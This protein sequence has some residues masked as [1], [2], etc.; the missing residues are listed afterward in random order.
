MGLGF[1]WKS[2]IA[3]EVL[4]IPRQAVGTELYNAKI[5]LDM[6]GL[7]AWT[8]VIILLSVLIEKGVLWLLPGG[9]KEENR[10]QAA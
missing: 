7:F 6:P 2:G 1:S 9:K 3:G 4:A 10:A 8:A 5:Y